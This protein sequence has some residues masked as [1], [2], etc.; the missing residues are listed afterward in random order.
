MTRTGKTIIL[1]SGVILITAIFLTIFYLISPLL[2]SS[3]NQEDNLIIASGSPEFSILT[4]VAKND[5]FFRTYGLNITFTSY[6]S[7]VEAVGILLA[8]DADLA[9]AAEFVGVNFISKSPELQIIGS[10]AKNEVI[11]FVIRGDRGISSAQDLKGKR[12]AVPKGTQA[13]FFLGRY[14]TLNRMNLSDITIQYLSPANMSQ[15]LVSGS[16]DAGI[17]WEP[18]VYNIQKNLTGNVIIWPAQNGQM[19]YWTTYTR[20]DVLKNKSDLIIRYFKALAEAE[21]YIN[22]HEEVVK[23]NM[24]MQLNL[25]DD[26]SDSIWNK[27]YYIQSFDQGM[28]VAMEDEARWIVKNNMSDYKAIPNFLNNINPDPMIHADPDAVSLIR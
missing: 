21:Q 26:Y 25:S 6:P 3:Y 10:S 9:Y 19:F 12:I 8:G 11:S 17:I 18:Y 27:S 4:L 7:G 23:T 20:T 5:G 1:I 13:E 22:S 15:S 28:I 2:T 16:S 14:L 24:K